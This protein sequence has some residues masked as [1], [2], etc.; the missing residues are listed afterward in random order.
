M[1]QNGYDDGLKDTPNEWVHPLNWDQERGSY[2]NNNGHVPVDDIPQESMS[3][4]G[5]NPTTLNKTFASSRCFMTQDLRHINLNHSS[6][7]VPIFQI[8]YGILLSELLKECHLRLKDLKFSENRAECAVMKENGQLKK[9]I[10]QRNP[11]DPQEYLTQNNIRHDFGR[12]RAVKRVISRVSYLSLV[13]QTNN[14][15][16]IDK[17]FISLNLTQI[18]TNRIY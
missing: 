3:Y 14:L 18:L 7:N 13:S 11:Q 4:N 17:I 1:Y 12:Y 16:L 2:C 9:I 8:E 10:I 5:Q 15:A 6:Q